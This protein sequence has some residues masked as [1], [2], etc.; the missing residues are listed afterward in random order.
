MPGSDFQE[1]INKQGLK[2]IE[3]LRA[4]VKQ[5]WIKCCEADNVDPGSKFVVFSD[6]N[7]FTPFYNNA[8][9]QLWEAEGNYKAGGYVGLRMDN[10]KKR[11]GGRPK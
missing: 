5:L 10:P 6:D 3:G 1:N 11:K 2:Y 7:Q 9:K 4:T 8:L